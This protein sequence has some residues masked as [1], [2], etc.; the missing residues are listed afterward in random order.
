[1][2][3]QGQHASSES[4]PSETLQ[5]PICPPCFCRCLG[6]SLPGSLLSPQPALPTPHAAGSLGQA[7]LDPLTPGWPVTVSDHRSKLMTF[8]MVCSQHLV[9]VDNLG[10]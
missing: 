2:G 9:A 6:K 5:R 8:G 1:M 7:C 4:R 3:L 10:W